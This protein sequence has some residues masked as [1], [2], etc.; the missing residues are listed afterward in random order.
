M[1][2]LKALTRQQRLHDDSFIARSPSTAFTAPPTQCDYD[3][4]DYEED[5]D[6]EEEG[7]E[8]EAAEGA[9]EDDNTIHSDFRL[10]ESSDTDPEFYDTSWSFIGTEI[11][12]VNTSKTEIGLVMEN[13]RKDEV[14][15]APNRFSSCSR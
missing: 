3:V 8:E 14:S 13:E 12:G 4:F 15:V 2:L 11:S 7:E 1:K 9:D 10:L 5:D 6:A